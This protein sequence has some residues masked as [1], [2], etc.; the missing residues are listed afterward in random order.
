MSSDGGIGSASRHAGRAKFESKGFLL[1]RKIFIVFVAVLLLVT[2][3]AQAKT[4]AGFT[5]NYIDTNSGFESGLTSWTTGGV[6][7]ATGNCYSSNMANFIP[8]PPGRWLQRDQFQV[9]DT[10][11]SY[12]LVYRAWLVNDANNFYDELKVRVTNDDTG[13]YEE[14]VLH[15]SNYTNACGSNEFNLVNDYDGARVTV[16]FIMGNFTIRT[17]QVDDVGFFATY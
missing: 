12:K 15:G 17:W 14:Q 8:G 6:T 7:V 1:M 11:T 2:P 3:Y 16:K 9:D 13:V 10:F 5:C 4:C